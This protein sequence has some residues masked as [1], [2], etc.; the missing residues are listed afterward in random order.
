M[1]DHETAQGSQ[2]SGE[3][4]EST[5]NGFSAMVKTRWYARKKLVLAGLPIPPELKPLPRSGG[6]GRQKPYVDEK[7]ARRRKQWRDYQTR[8]LTKAQTKAQT[9]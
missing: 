1:I 5:G 8:K 6:K 2:K 7:T 4:L 9:K 3:W